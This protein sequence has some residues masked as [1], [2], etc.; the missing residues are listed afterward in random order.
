M[1]IVL[2]ILLLVLAYLCGAIP[3]G[4][5]I[6]KKKSGKNLLNLGSGNVGSTNVRRV[7]GSKLALVTQLLDMLKGFLPVAIYLLLKTE[8]VL[9][10]YPYLLAIGAIIGHDFSVFLN[11]KGGKGVNTTLGASIMLAPYAV[12]AS[13]MIYYLV[14]WRFRYVSLGSLAL[15][16]ALPLVEF[17]V[18]GASPTFYYLGICTFLSVFLHRANI[19]RLINGT[20]LPS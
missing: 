10:Y 18:N 5:I 13:V 4:Y 20:E 6:T 15:A 17:L 16:V 14:K 12:L 1:Q 9:P 11:F 19:L 8:T 7:L 2:E 3:F